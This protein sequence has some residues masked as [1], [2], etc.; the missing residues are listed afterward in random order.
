MLTKRGSTAQAS[1]HASRLHIRL[2]RLATAAFQPR[3]EKQS[4]TASL[5]TTASQASVLT[6]QWL[7][8]A[9]VALLQEDQMSATN[10]VAIVEGRRALA[11]NC[12][13]GGFQ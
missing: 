7:R 12:S 13:S 11:R 10:S 1:S 8:G 9:Q 3:C 5:M 4:K 2:F 6:S